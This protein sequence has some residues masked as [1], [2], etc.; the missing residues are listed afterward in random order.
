V[1]VD[2]RDSDA[3]AQALLRLSE[4]EEL[5]RSLIRRGEARVREFSWE[6]AVRQTWAVY[7][8][9]TARSA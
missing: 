9:L 8:Q 4:D 5:R 6:N 1:L 2:P 3:L 7:A